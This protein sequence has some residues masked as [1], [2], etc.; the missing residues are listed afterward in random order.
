MISFAHFLQRTT[1]LTAL[2]MS[3]KT[4]VTRVATPDSQNFHS[5]LIILMDMFNVEVM[6]TLTLLMS[7]KAPHSGKMKV[8]MLNTSSQLSSV[9][10]KRWNV[11][12]IACLKYNN[13]KKWKWIWVVSYHWS[14]SACTRMSSISSRL[15]IQSQECKFLIR[16]YLCFLCM[17]LSCKYGQHNWKVT[18]FQTDGI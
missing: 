7:G 5:C 14:C 12:V 17:Q 15:H 18:Q 8:V 3:P 6:T 16:I 2:P 10:L 4:P 1:R 11:K 9:M 13:H